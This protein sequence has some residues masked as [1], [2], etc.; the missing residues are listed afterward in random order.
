MKIRSVRHK[1]LRRLIEDEDVSGFQPS[2]TGKL[3]VMIASRQDMGSEDE[4]RTV[5]TW[6]A[7]RLVADRKGAWALH[8]TRNWRLTFEIDRDAVEIIDLDYVDYH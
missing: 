5:P 4:L 6:K 7:H 2:I 8:V 1:G 3:R